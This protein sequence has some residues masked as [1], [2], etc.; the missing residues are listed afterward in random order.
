MTQPDLFAPLEPPED[1]AQRLQGLTDLLAL[2]G[3][4]QR[5]ERGAPGGV[6]RELERRIEGTALKL[7]E[8]QGNWRRTG[9]DTMVRVQP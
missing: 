4:M 9:P 7:L 2:L 5:L 3:A 1:G 8:R 6:C